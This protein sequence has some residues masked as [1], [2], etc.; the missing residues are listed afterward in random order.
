VSEER[1]TN[2]E[3]EECKYIE[4]KVKKMKKNFEMEKEGMDLRYI[5][6]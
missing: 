1:L 2:Y 3:C 5:V 6:R 4:L